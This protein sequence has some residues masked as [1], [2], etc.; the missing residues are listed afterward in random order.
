MDKIRYSEGL[1]E[2]AMKKAPICSAWCNWRSTA[3]RNNCMIVVMV[4]SGGWIADLLE[5]NRFTKCAG[6]EDRITPL[7]ACAPN[8]PTS[9]V[10]ICSVLQDPIPRALHLR[11]FELRRCFLLALA[12]PSSSVTWSS[13]IMSL[14]LPTSLA[15][16]LERLP[17]R[18]GLRVR[19]ARV[20]GSLLPRAPSNHV[21]NACFWASSI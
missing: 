15:V 3:A 18:Q 8:P 21:K 16:R 14:L 20:W 2:V 7:Q 10:Q 19:A 12:L 4:C 11:H 6:I 13:S 9:D 1:A 5:F 17:G